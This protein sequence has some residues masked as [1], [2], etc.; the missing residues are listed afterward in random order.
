MF[1]FLGAV[2]LTMVLAYLP[3]WTKLVEMWSESEENSHG[4]LI[5][6][7]SLYAVW[8]KREVL[9]KT[10][11]QGSSWGLALTCL[12]LAIY[13]VSYYGEIVTVQSLSLIAVTMGMALYLLGWAMIKE[14][15]FP[16][17]FLLFMIPVPAQIY[18]WL[19]I[20]LQLF[21]SKVSVA[22]AQA[23]NVPI[24]REGNVL[25][26][27]QRTLQ[28]VQACSGLRSM[29]SLLALSATYGH[30]TLKSPLPKGI[31]FLSGIPIA[32][33]V[34]IVRVFIMIIAFHYFDINLTEGTVH[35]YFGVG[36]FLL[37]L[38]LT[39]LMRE[40]LVKWDKSNIQN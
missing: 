39:G 14:L 24:Y 2:L 28:V 10:P 30:F 36:I 32:I 26:L 4:Y 17:F 15:L 35:T 12:S 1:V 40:I 16:L 22:C 34:N 11:I 18:S 29:I 38:I 25:H 23:I 5:L 9:A 7:I 37:A 8:C 3:V 19:T 20:P 13:I 33:A 27:P 31:L 21:V 6:P